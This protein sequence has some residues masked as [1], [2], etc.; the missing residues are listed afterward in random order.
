MLVKLQFNIVNDTE[1]M[2]KDVYVIH[3][4]A[5]NFIDVINMERLENKQDPT[6]PVQLRIL[7]SQPDIWTVLFTDT[8]GQVWGVVG[9]G[10]VVHSNTKV[11]TIVTVQIEASH[12]NLKIG[13]ETIGSAPLQKI[14]TNQV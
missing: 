7:S 8:R 11:G 10:M 5:S 14:P 3:A 6:S 9:V 4:T 2:I 13:S 1:D 12:V